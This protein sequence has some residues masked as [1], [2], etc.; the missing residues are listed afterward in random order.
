MQAVHGYHVCLNQVSIDRTVVVYRLLHEGVN[1]K[2][3][4]FQASYPC[5]ARWMWGQLF[6][7]TASED[8]H[9]TC[10]QW[11]SGHCS[12]AFPWCLAVPHVQPSWKTWEIGNRQIWHSSNRLEVRS[13]FRITH[14]HTRLLLRALSIQQMNMGEVSACTA[15]CDIWTSIGQVLLSLGSKDVQNVSPPILTLLVVRT[16]P[17]FFPMSY[18]IHQIP[19]CEF[20]MSRTHTGSFM[21]LNICCLRNMHQPVL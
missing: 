11:W 4:K 9:C 1:L 16:F 5:G 18:L 14:T 3:E 10:V 17:E 12:C 6:P 21:T 15:D 20:A 7:W 19:S 2:A 8:K 13:Y